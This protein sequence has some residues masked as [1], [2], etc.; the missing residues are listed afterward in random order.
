MTIEE[1]KGTLDDMQSKNAALASDMEAKN[2]AIENLD[3]S[4]KSLDT[5]IKAL[6]K[7]AVTTAPTDWKSYIRQQFEANRPA[8]ELA[9]KQG[10]K[11]GE[12]IEFKTNPA[13]IGTSNVTG[14]FLGVNIDPTIYAAPAPAN[15]FI[16]AFGQRPCVGNKLG[17][18]EAAG[19]AS[20]SV[21]YVAE[22]AQNTNLVDFTFTEVTR[23]Y[24]KIA[25]KIQMSTE[26]EDWFEAL[27]D[28][29]VNEGA[30]LIKAKFD[31]EIYNGDGH[32]TN[33]PTDVYGLKA[34]ATAFSA[35][36]AG[37]VTD[38]NE[39]DV[40]EDARMQIAKE[41]FNANVAFVTWAIYAAI[42]N[43]KN[44]AGSYLYNEALGM[45]NGIRIFPTSA[46]GAGEILVADSN[47]V[48]VYGGDNSYEL[49]IVRN[50]DYDRNDIYFRKRC[51]VKVATSNKKG[52]IYVSSAATAIAALLKDSPLAEL[53][54]EDHVFKTAAQSAQV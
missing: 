39:A 16:A 49:E 23:K 36:A 48:S 47:C 30:R 5:E 41:G 40:I 17:W 37:A 28:W 7:K 54:D 45:L 34:A 38:A 25:A 22:L 29:C 51:Q 13:A 50:A 6:A 9:W 42:K 19:N 32:D 3:A 2:T 4:V 20:N 24:A 52:L 44:A 11:K 53:A 27:Y 10:T 26:F 43:L 46:L 12:P 18:I 8:L 1:L 35:L 15:A 33:H 31:Y 21:G 14:N